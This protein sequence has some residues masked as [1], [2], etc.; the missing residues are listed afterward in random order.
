MLYNVYINFKHIKVI[1]MDKQKVLDKIKKCLNLSKSSNPNE[2]AIA[3][4]QMRK[5]MDEY[6]VSMGDVQDSMINS[7]LHHSKRKMQWKKDLANL[8]A[9]AFDCEFFYSS[10]GLHFVG[11]DS[12][13]EIALYAYETLSRQLDADRKKYMANNHLNNTTKARNL[14]SYTY[15][16]G[17]LS[18]IRAIVDKIVPKEDELEIISKYLAKHYSIKTVS[19]KQVVAG[20]EK[21]SQAMDQG[22]NDGQKANLFHATSGRDQARI[23]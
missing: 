20:G 19:R 23:A 7:A 6:K 13:A 10:H 2:A 14:F 9:Q 17:W 1:K 5:L 4:K 21:G 8:I 15:C 3:L 16:V 18:Q 11:V 12:N 22:R